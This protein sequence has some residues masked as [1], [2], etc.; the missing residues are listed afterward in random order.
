ME[1]LGWETKLVHNTIVYLKKFPLWGRFAKIPRPEN[2]KFFEEIDRLKK[3]SHIFKFN[4]APN[5]RTDD[6]NYHIY[7]KRLFSSGFKINHFPF[8]PTTTIHI[9]LSPSPDKI[10]QFFSEAKR[11]GVRRAQ[12]NGVI[13]KETTDIDAFIKIR[14][15]QYSP[16]GF[17]VT[18]EMKILWKNF[19]P[20]NASLLLAY[21]QSIHS[22]LT[23][24]NTAAGSGVNTPL[25]GI[26]ML[27][28]DRIA[29]YW[30]ASALQSGK[31]LF[32]PT[33]L[34][35]EAL[36]LAKRKGNKIFDFEGICDERFPRASESW[37]GFT[38][39]KEG[40]GGKT[41]EFMENFQ[42]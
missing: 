16:F 6:S 38:K 32:A 8:N 5:V 30:Y 37:K 4:I 13:I 35:W 15:K 19:F 28:Y 11:R 1:D 31:T 17:M 41:A 22:T 2:L 12:K 23:P 20:K 21:E 29:Y 33:L 36:K 3:E 40:F 34:V 14:K 27:Y 39:F 10:F 7:K 24:K 25:G 18:K 9:N 42:I 26:L